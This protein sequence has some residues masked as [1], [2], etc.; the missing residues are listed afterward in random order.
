[1]LEVAMFIGVLA[2]SL[3]TGAALYVSWV[4]HPARMTLEP[5]NAA[6]QWV[7]STTRALRMQAPLAGVGVIAALGAGFMGGGAAWLIAGVLLALVLPVTL[8]LLAP[9]NHML[10]EPPRELSAREIVELLEKW[11][12][13]HMIRSALGSAAT[14]LM[15]W[16]MTAP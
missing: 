13:L 9:T 11:G 15:L 4:E 7:P 3:F 14:L 6:K 12:R 2:T 5:A 8:V 16:E 1:M 10:L